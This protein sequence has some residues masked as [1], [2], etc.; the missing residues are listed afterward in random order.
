MP[1]MTATEARRTLF[2]LIK[3]VNDDHDVVRITS[4]GGVGVLMSEADYEAL[5]TTQHLFSTAAN[6][7]RLNKSLADARAGRVEYH[8]L[9]RL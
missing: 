5:V 7:A 3:K 2:P 1:T 6:A 4:K 9:D 8:D